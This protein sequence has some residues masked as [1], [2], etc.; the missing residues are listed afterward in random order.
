MKILPSSLVTKL[1]C[2][3]VGLGITAVS[4]LAGAESKPSIKIGYVAGWSDSVATTFVAAE[5]MRKNLGYDVK[6]VPVDAGLMWQAWPRV[7]TT[8]VWM[9]PCRPGCRPLTVLITTS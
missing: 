3:S 5:V 2:L 4:G 1:C 7:R 8:A 9:P 6:L